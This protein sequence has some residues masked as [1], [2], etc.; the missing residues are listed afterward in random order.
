MLR[1]NKSR[2]LFREAKTVLCGGVN[3]PVRAFKGVGGTPVF[4]E[5]GAG[6]RLIDAD[7]NR[8]IDFCQSWGALALGHAHPAVVRA[9]ARQAANGTSFGAPT[10]LETQLALLL[11]KYYPSCQ[12]FRF[13]SSGTEA[14]MTAIRLARGFTGRSKIIKFEGCYHGHMDSL[15][16]KGGSGLATLGKPDSAGIPAGFT[17]E[18]IVLPYNDREALAAAFRKYADI[19]AIVIEPIAGNMGVI[20][21]DPGF[22]AMARSHTKRRGALLIFDEVITGFR[23]S[24]GG[25]QALYGIR[26]DL[27]T[28]GK[29][30][31]GGLPVGALGGPASILKHLAPEGDVY[32]AGT[33][34][35]NPVSMAAGIQTLQLLTSKGTFRKTATAA[36]YFVRE[37]RAVFA[38]NRIPASVPWIG[39]I[40][41]VYFGAESPSAFTEITSAHKARYRRFFHHML[42]RGIYLAPSAYESFFVSAAHGKPE[43][44]ATLRAAASFRG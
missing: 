6:P 30:I 9:I 2:A 5:K 34:S 11:K 39:T 19:A 3:S 14:V 4:F 26:P 18:T 21:A 25:A 38:K 22:L 23:A 15:L 10:R 40:F 43:F 33:L 28:L 1:T 44:A 8:Y 13:T 41:G 29:V 35:G 42:E 27:T 32:Q 36:G 20:S 12:K 37:L 17:H 24:L 31:G 16:V 7:G